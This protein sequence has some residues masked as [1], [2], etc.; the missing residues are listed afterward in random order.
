MNPP[1]NNL[2]TRTAPI[3]RIYLYLCALSIPKHPIIFNFQ[4]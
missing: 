1:S 2:K 3:T 4:N